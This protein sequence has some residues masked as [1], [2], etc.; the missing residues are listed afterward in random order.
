MIWKIFSNS[1]LLGF[2]GKA[3]Y[4]WTVDDARCPLTT[5]LFGY[6][7]LFPLRLAIFKRAICAERRLER[8]VPSQFTISKISIRV[9]SWSARSDKILAIALKAFAICSSP[10]EIQPYP[11][12]RVPAGRISENPTPAFLQDIYRPLICPQLLPM[13]SQ[14]LQ[15]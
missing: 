8:I 9:K 2:D 4:Y 7:K 13:R 11:F 3:S 14:S 6:S 15:P 12:K 10:D 5:T 1:A